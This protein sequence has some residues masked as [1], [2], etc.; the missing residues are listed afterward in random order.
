MAQQEGRSV[1]NRMEVYESEKVPS[2]WVVIPTWNRKDEIQECLN[3]VLVS[4]YINLNIVVIDNGSTDDTAHLISENY[5]QINLIQLNK[6]IGASAASNMGFEYALKKGAKYLLRLDSDMLIDKSMISEMVKFAVS[7]SSLGLI[8]PKILRYDQPDIIWYTGAKRH[9]FFIVSRAK[10]FN[11]K[12][13]GGESSN[14]EIDFAPSAA[15]LLSATVVKKTKGFDEDYFVYFEDYDLCI[16][17][18]KLDKNIFYCPAA[19]AWHKIGSDKLSDFGLMQYQKSKMIFYRKHS[20]GMHSFLLIIFSFFHIIYRSMFKASG[21]HIK[22]ALK[23]MIK[24]LK[25]P[26]DLH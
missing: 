25:F 17:I 5:P 7:D 11:V 6:N 1:T 24:G 3:S 2:V 9:S 4:D 23:G 16:R 8:F 21:E 14:F 22:P 20:S 15:I 10:D 19:K 26:L 13:G 18:K 12:D